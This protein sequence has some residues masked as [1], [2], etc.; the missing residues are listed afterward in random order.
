MSHPHVAHAHHAQPHACKTAGVAPSY[1]LPACLQ[2]MNERV[3]DR[4]GPA[5]AGPGNHVPGQLR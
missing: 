4:T 3:F 5:L 1:I 2:G